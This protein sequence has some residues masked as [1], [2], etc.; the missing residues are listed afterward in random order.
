MTYRL[1]RLL[2]ASY[3]NYRIDTDDMNVL[4]GEAQNRNRG[5]FAVVIY[6]MLFHTE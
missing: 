4:L 3:T 2:G 1:F 6:Q 5:E